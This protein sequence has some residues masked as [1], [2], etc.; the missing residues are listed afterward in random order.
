MAQH[1]YEDVR[2]LCRERLQN[3]NDE[4]FLYHFYLDQAL[5]RLGELDEALRVNEQTI[6][7]AFSESNKF[8][9]REHRVEILHQA[10]RSADALAEC[11]KLLKD[12]PQARYAPAVRHKMAAIL[13]H[14]RKF[15]ESETILRQL[16]EADPN[17][18]QTLNTLGYELADQNRR[19]DEAERLVR[20]AL[21]LDRRA[22]Q[23]GDDAESPADDE[24]NPAYLDSLAW[25]LFRKGQLA[26]GRKLLEE[27]T[28]RRGG[29]D[30]PTLWDHLGDIHYRLGD[31]EKARAAW[32][33]ALEYYAREPLA[34]KD[35]R[36][37]EV[38][39]KLNVLK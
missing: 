22:R 39:R 29:R 2:S 3:A 31:V 28:T 36:L 15:A 32:Q 13:S 9:A 23:F 5:M 16:L 7:L 37:G 6:A 18:V 38:A 20:R 12:L 30:E 27:A 26:E 34:K 4:Q 14:E 17:D 24:D 25:V 10:G 19:L 35:G 33:K 21:E 8:A 1:K 11:E